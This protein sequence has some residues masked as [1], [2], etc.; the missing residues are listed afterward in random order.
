MS[1]FEERGITHLDLHGTK[2][3]DVE[4]QVIN[5]VYQF[6]DLLPLIIICGNS[7]KMIDITSTALTSV[8]ISFSSPRFGIIR[9]EGF[10]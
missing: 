7:N 6:Q 9:V 3:Q 2:H 4:L 10:N 5:F 8:N 1:V